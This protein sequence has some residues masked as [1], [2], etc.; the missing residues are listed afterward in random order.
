VVESWNQPASGSG[1]YGTT[2]AGEGEFKEKAAHLGGVARDQ[3]KTQ[4]TSQKG[5]LAE[6]LGSVSEVLEQ[7]SQQLRQDDRAGMADFPDAAARQLR[8]LS[9]QLGQTDL[10]QLVQQAQRAARERPALF[11]GAAFGLGVLGA[12]FLKSSPSTAGTS[13]YVSHSP[14]TST[15]GR[16]DDIQPRMETTGLPDGNSGPYAGASRP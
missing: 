4:L 13:S 11:I 2:Q 7:S 1:S 3:L 16:G 6:Q 14:V 5:K 10:D 8:S 15:S 9:D 12:R